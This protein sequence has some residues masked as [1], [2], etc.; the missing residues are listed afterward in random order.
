MDRRHRCDCDDASGNA[1]HQEQGDIHYPDRYFGTFSDPYVQAD[2]PRGVNESLENG[3]Y[4]SKFVLP[5]Y[6]F[7]TDCRQN[8]F[9]N[10]ILRMGQITAYRTPKEP[11]MKKTIA[12]FLIPLLAAA[13]IHVNEATD[14]Q[15][16]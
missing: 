6:H 2:L 13:C 8:Y 11:N 16:L 10:P 7:D 15:V 12:F 3:I 4:Y 14:G 9:Y 1:H 5:V